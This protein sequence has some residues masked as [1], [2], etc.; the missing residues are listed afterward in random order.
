MASPIK[1]A[2]VVLR[3]GQLGPMRDWYQMVLEARVVFENDFLVFLTYDDEHHRIALADTKAV[4]RPT[5][6]M[7]GL[8]H[9]S[10]TYATLEDLLSTYERLD[11]AGVEPYWC[12]NHGP[13]TS[14]YFADPD[15]NHV[16]LQFD[17]F[18]DVADGEAFMHSP[19]FEN[20][21]I[22]VEF[23]PRQLLER[24]RRGDPLEELVQQGS[25]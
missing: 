20:N 23:D 6:T 14:M 5:R 7:T 22:G 10:F 24:F 17:N 21:P 13:T 18:D 12:I 15:G 8:E 3:T 4:D 25:A 9:V 11:T 1:L 2:H 16:E 19:V